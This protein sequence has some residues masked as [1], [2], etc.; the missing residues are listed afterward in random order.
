MGGTFAW[1]AQFQKFKVKLLEPSHPSVKGIPKEWEREDEFYFA[2]ELFPGIKTVAANDITTLNTT[3]TVQRNL[4]IKNAGTYT[5]LYPSVWTHAYDGGHTWVTTLGH[6]K[7]DY[8][9]PVY[10]QHILQG[11]RFIASQVKNID[12]SKA[13][14]DSRDAPVKY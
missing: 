10:V 12:F 14:A 5:E 8:K 11:I 7:K 13:Y 1:H 6:H 3:D 9:D 2:K 4:I